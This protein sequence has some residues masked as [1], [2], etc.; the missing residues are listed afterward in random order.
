MKW[1]PSILAL[2]LLL[3]FLYLT[4]PAFRSPK[5][6]LKYFVLY[7][8]ALFVYHI[9]DAMLWGGLWNYEIVR[10]IA[11]V[12]FYFEIPCLLALVYALLPKESRGTPFRVITAVLCLPWLYALVVVGS[13]P[14]VFLEGKGVKYEDI[15]YALVLAYLIAIIFIY[16]VGMKGAKKLEG[17]MKDFLKKICLASLVML[18]GYVLLWS[19]MDIVKDDYTFLFG[20]VT[21]I[22]LLIVRLPLMKVLK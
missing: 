5:T 8:L 11:S 19:S 17:D 6:Y 10:R 20:I 7:L 22:W 3:Y 1:L 15:M 14:L 13:S 18:I 9:G 12:G 21:I 2:L 16:I 4:V